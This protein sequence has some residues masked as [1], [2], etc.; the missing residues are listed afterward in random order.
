MNLVLEGLLVD[1]LRSN[2]DDCGAWGGEVFWFLEESG[3][4]WSGDHGHHTR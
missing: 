1:S 4:N 2:K 3:S